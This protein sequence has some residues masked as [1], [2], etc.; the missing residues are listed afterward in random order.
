MDSCDTAY[1]SFGSGFVTPG[2]PLEILVRATGCGHLCQLYSGGENPWHLIDFG[3][4]IRTAAQ[5]NEQLLRRHNRQK[6]GGA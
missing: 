6:Q 3:Q 4:S 2:A 1:G 5:I